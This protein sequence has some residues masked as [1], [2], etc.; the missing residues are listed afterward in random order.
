ARGQ[1]DVR[2]TTPVAA[3]AITGTSG[4]LAYAADT[5]FR[6]RCRDGTWTCHVGERVRH[7]KPT[8]Q[9]D[10]SMTRHVEVVKVV[11]TAQ[12]GDSFGGLSEAETLSLV[13]D[14]DGRGAIGF[15]GAGT[16]A[17][18]TVKPPR[19]HGPKKPKKPKK[20][21]RRS[22][23]IRPPKIIRPPIKGDDM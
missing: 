4:D 2:I 7:V 14:G 15:S 10:S 9:T 13:N 8:E 22:S 1:S 23:Y 18:A 17:G 21:K 12:L 19:H 16:R 5:G 3:L 11:A 20:P 6:L